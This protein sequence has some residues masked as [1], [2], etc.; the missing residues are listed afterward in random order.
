MT[1]LTCTA[2]VCQDGL[3]EIPKSIQEELR[4][5]QGDEVEVILRKS[6]THHRKRTKNPLYRLVGIGKGGPPNGA[7]N[8]DKYLYSKKST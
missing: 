1:T 2:R 3:L 5:Q 6:V 8:H 4:L 7:E